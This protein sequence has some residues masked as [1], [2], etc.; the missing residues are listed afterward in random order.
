M[1]LLRAGAADADHDA[2]DLALGA[3]L[4]APHAVAVG[5]KDEFTFRIGAPGLDRGLRIA[6]G[7]D[8]RLGVRHRLAVGGSELRRHLVGREEVEGICPRFGEHAQ[9]CG[10]QANGGP[11]R[12]GRRSAEK[13]GHSLNIA[14]FR[15]GAM[16]A[17]DTFLA[18]PSAAMAKAG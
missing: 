13:R 16:G 5:V 8:P 7:E 3:G 11:T 12:D 17:G 10:Q 15:G 1:L 9:R 18:W 14:I 6:R 4:G 2:R